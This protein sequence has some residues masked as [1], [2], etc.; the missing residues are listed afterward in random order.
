MVSPDL[1]GKIAGCGHDSTLIWRKDNKMAE[2]ENIEQA[3]EEGYDKGYEDGYTKGHEE[4]YEK[5]RKVGKVTYKNKSL[6][7][8]NRQHNAKVGRGKK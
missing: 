5:G 1:A 2:E 7:N 6:D 8:A 4:G 3:R